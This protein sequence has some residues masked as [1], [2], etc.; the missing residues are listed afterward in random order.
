ME[1]SKYEYAY[2]QVN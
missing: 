1:E 2:I